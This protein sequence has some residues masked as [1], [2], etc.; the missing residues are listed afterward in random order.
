MYITPRYTHGY[1]VVRWI[2]G[3]P[4]QR[5]DNTKT[6]ASRSGGVAFLQVWRVVGGGAP[7]IVHIIARYDI[8]EAAGAD[9][10]RWSNHLTQSKYLVDFKTVCNVT[11]S[12][13]PRAKSGSSS[14]VL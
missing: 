13:L 11:L 5:A 7:L 10:I 6:L 12:F 2:P 3:H 4:P 1:T 14:C 9:A 8:N